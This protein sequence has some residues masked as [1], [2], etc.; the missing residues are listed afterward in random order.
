MD[1]FTAFLPAPVQAG[2]LPMELH[3]SIPMENISGGT[4]SNP[5]PKP[6]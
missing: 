3:G 5:P 6:K 4:M 1:L 2:V